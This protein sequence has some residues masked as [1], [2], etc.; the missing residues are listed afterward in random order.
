METNIFYNRIMKLKKERN[1][2]MKD[3]IS[4]IGVSETAINNWKNQDIKSNNLIA[5][6]NYFNVSTDYLLGLTEKRDAETVS[7]RIPFEKLELLEFISQLSLSEKQY[8]MLLDAVK[9]ILR[10]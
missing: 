1:L 10:F 9:G 8:T 3:L 7:S 5:A 6:A 2:T 4:G